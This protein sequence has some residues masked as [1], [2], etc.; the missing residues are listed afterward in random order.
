MNMLLRVHVALKW[1]AR[2][3]SDRPD[4]LAFG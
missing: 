3:S 2:I 1:H 4:I